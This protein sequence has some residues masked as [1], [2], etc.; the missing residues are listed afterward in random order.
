ML[1]A[2]EE[3]TYESLQRLVFCQACLTEALRLYPPAPLTVRTLEEDLTLDG[4]VLP[5]GTMVY[6]PIWWIH[7]Y[8]PNWGADAEAFRPERH[9][10]DDGGEPRAEGKTANSYRFLA[11]SGGQRNCIGQ[12]FAMLEATTLLVVL[13]RRC[14]FE[15]PEGSSPPRAVSTGVVQKPEGGLRL[16][17]RARA[18]A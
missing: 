10:G 17:V 4:H 9:L 16:H 13:L 11:F 12:R 5:K 2:E 3:P 18:R 7:R 14:R 1:G 6:M 15:L 8:A